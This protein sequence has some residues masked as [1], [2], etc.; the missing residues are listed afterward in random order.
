MPTGFN[1]KK[2]F[3]SKIQN[4]MFEKITSSL[5]TTKSLEVITEQYR[6]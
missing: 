1:T 5:K 4:D 3:G 2:S 6:S